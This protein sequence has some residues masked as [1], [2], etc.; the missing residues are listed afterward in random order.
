MNQAQIYAEM[1]KGMQ[2]D[3]QQGQQ[4]PESGGPQGP[5]SNS[6]QPTNM[7][8]PQ[9]PAQGTQPSDLTGSGNGTI[10]TGGVPAAGE[11]QFAGNASQFE[12]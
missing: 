3:A 4:Q 2:P 8:A 10:G 5:S 1:L 12:E 11:S 7:G 9:Q 6:G